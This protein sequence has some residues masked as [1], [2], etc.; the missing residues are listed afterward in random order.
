[1]F[2]QNLVKAHFKIP[3]ESCLTKVIVKMSISKAHILFEEAVST[4]GFQLL[5]CTVQCFALHDKKFESQ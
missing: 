5:N 3:S 1:M 4:N 2:K